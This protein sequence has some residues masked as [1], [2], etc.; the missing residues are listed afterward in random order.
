M[1][2]YGPGG[3]SPGNRDQTPGMER[4]PPGIPGNIK[5]EPMVSNCI[6]HGYSSFI[7]TDGRRDRAIIWGE[8][9]EV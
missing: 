2:R 7:H 6:I 3:V 8:D 5:S 4:P 9:G 1:E